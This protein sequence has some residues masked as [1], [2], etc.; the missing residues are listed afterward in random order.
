MMSFKKSLCAVIWSLVMLTFMFYIYALLFMHGLLDVLTNFDEVSDDFKSDVAEYFGS[1]GQ[2]MASL[3]MAVTGGNDWIVYYSVM[4]QAG[5]VFELLFIFFVF[6]F[7]FAV[8]SILTGTFVE[9]SVS[10][11]QPDR[12]DQVLA[13]RAKAAKQT[14]EFRHMC[15]L[16]DEDNS[17]AISW[18]EFEK[19]MHND[20]M[21]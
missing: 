21:V 7:S 8:L 6:F 20:V 15:E 13:A 16:L 9:K 17:G 14:L 12:D 18:K 4:Q 2:S 19:Y 1:L 3:Y 11:A 5:V 10:A